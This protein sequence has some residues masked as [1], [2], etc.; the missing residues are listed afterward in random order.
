MDEFYR[1]WRRRLVANAVLIFALAGVVGLAY[2]WSLGRDDYPCASA[3]AKVACDTAVYPPPCATDNPCLTDS[4]LEHRLSTAHQQGLLHALLLFVIGF[5]APYLRVG[6]NLFSLAAWLLLIACWAAPLTDA[7]KALATHPFF[8]GLSGDKLFAELLRNVAALGGLATMAAFFVLVGRAGWEIVRSGVAPETWWNW[9]KLVSAR[10]RRV[11]E[12]ELLEDLL[13]DVQEAMRLRMRVRAFGGR[14]SWSAIAPTDDAMIDMRRL[15]RIEGLATRSAPPGDPL[16][17]PET[18]HVV[19]AEAGVT[20]REL[21]TWLAERGR[22]LATTPVNPWVQLGGALA[23]GCHGTGVHHA[24]LTALVTELWIVQYYPGGFS[25]VSVL[26]HYARP[27]APRSTANAPDWDNWDALMVNLGCLGVMYRVSLECRP[28]Y[29]VRIQDTAFPM[30]ATLLSPG[31][32]A[33]IVDKNEF[34]EIFW[35]PYNDDCFVR[36]WKAVPDTKVPGFSLWFWVSQWLVAKFGGP[37]FSVLV[38]LTPFLTPRLMRLF[39]AAFGKLNALVPA[40]DAMQ[41]QRY[42]LPVF[43]VGH[44]ILLDPIAAHRFEAFQTAWFEV[45]DRLW[46][47]RHRGE[48]PQNL[49]LHARF[50]R[51]ASAFLAPNGGEKNQWAFI[52]VITHANTPLHEA[53]FERIE[54]TWYRLGGRP[55]WGKMTYQ[56]DQLAVNYSLA[57][58]SAFAKVRRDMDPNEVFLNDYVR[59]ALHL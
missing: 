33:D 55:H 26:V 15:R 31:A 24:P 5:A 29:N 36:T 21:S 56:V 27:A 46:T 30:E 14:F 32:L 48:Y 22:M 9:A 52:E 57:D 1:R 20:I 34:S 53:H 41:Y 17:E 44:A 54:R 3:G 25:P 42:F 18:T 45:V 10:P 47:A 16:W 19:T 6:K 11:Y 58:L 28:L 35:F 37:P 13:F 23:L 2:L 51:G 43:D 4:V 49:A 50:G 59:E 8:P 40:P 7:L 12:P 39:H 38:T